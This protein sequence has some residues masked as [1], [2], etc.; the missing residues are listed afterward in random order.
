V[1]RRRLATLVLTA[2]AAA[3]AVTAIPPAFR[4]AALRAPIASVQRVLRAFG[5][6]PGLAVF[7][8]GYEDRVLVRQDCIRVVARDIS[9][10]VRVLAPPDDR[11]VTRGVRVVVPWTEGGMRAWVLRAPPGVAEPALGDWVCRGPLWGSSDWSEVT[12]IWTQP[13]VELRSGREGVA[14]AAYFVWR[15]D[16]PAL[17][18]R[19]MRPSDAAMRAVESRLG[20]EPL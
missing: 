10:D 15:C 20:V 13:W 18:E 4:P 14:N 8:T 19:V 11:C 6:V 12:V 1:T 16:P 5:I 17:V 3:L 9:G 2:Y 7:E